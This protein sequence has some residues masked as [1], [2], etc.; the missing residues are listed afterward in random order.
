MEDNETYFDN[1]SLLETQK[2]YS[3]SFVQ[4]RQIPCSLIAEK[5]KKRFE[6]ILKV[7]WII[8]LHFIKFIDNKFSSEIFSCFDLRV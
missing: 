4:T 2:L 1:L 7:A 8:F 5:K 3:L 6:L